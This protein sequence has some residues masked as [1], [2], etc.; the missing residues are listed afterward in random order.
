M[1]PISSG[2]FS[3]PIPSMIINMGWA[4]TMVTKH[5]KHTG[6]SRTNFKSKNTVNISISPKLSF[7]SCFI[8]SLCSESQ[9]QKYASKPTKARKHIRGAIF[10]GCL[11]VI[12]VDLD[13]VGDKFA[14]NSA[15]KTAEKT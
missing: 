3:F 11:W 5:I 1:I 4:T 7:L 15:P 2:G 13:A 12:V 10:F 6:S 9:S 14:A 8:L